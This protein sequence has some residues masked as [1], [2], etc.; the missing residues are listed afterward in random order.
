MAQYATSA[1]WQ[2]HQVQAQ[3]QQQLYPHLLWPQSNAFLAGSASTSC[4]SW[5]PASP[6]QPVQPVQS[7][8]CT[9]WPPRSPSPPW[10][11]QRDP[12]VEAMIQEL[13]IT[14]SEEQDFAWIAEYGIQADVLPPPWTKHLDCGTGCVYFVD[15]ETQAAT[16]ESPLIPCLQRVLGLGRRYLESPS[17]DFF[18][19]AKLQL[20]SRLKADLNFW[21]GP[22]ESPEGEPYFANSQTGRSSWRDPRVDAQ[23]LFD[24]EGGLLDSLA[25]AL[26]PP[27][28]LKVPCFGS[29]ELRA[30][31]AM[32]RTETGAEVLTLDSPAGDQVTPRPVPDDA[33]TG[34]PTPRMPNRLTAIA[35]QDASEKTKSKLRSM[36][37][38]YSRLQAMLEEEL[39]S[40]RQRIREKY[41]ARLLRIA[42]EA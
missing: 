2:H 27:E 36:R 34:T 10:E 37:K 9:S 35:M 29:Q 41:K 21:H 6:V 8:S 12:A 20:W 15:S 23:L 1:G 40:Q 18:E 7:V 26:P 38:T 33:L 28:E 39:G 16:W 22:L 32:W 3:L 24:L 13:G 4:W 31:A 25:E 30:A 42:N 19:D 14:A 11:P 5:R 17:E